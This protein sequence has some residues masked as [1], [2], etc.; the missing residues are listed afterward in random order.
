[1]PCSSLV[2]ELKGVRVV[3]TTSYKASMLHL[4]NTENILLVTVSVS[5]K[6]EKLTGLGKYVAWCVNDSRRRRG[7]RDQRSKNQPTAILSDF[8]TKT[9]NAKIFEISPLQRNR[10]HHSQ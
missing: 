9:N 4:L 8:D 10:T 2:T 6:G 5:E 3:P 7:G 1:V